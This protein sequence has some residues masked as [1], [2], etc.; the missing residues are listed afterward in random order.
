MK[1]FTCCEGAAKLNWQPISRF[2]CDLQIAKCEKCHSSWMKTKD[3]VTEIYT[4]K[5]R[6]DLINGINRFSV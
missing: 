6:I 4:D 2:G 5:N 3:L 1:E